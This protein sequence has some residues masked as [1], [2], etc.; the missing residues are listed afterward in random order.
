MCYPA[1]QTLTPQALWDNLPLREHRKNTER[2]LASGQILELP[3]TVADLL[4]IH[5]NFCRDTNW[6]VLFYVL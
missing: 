6:T 4:L 3:I 2:E 1:E 5:V